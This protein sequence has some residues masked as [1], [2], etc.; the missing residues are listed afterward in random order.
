MQW[1]G[2]LERF[3]PWKTV[4]ERH[5][6]WSADGAWEQL[7]RQIQAAADAAGEIHW[8]V[9][10]DS[11]IAGR[12]STLSAPGPIRHWCSR[13]RGTKQQNT[14]AKPYGRVSTL[15]WWGVAGRKDLGR[16][17]GGFT[18]RLHLS[19]DGRCRPL[20]PIVAPGQRADCTQ[21]K[22]VVEKIRV[23]KSGPG[24]PRKKPDS[25]TTDKAYSNGPAAN[26][27]DDAASGT[28]SGE[29]RQSEPDPSPGE[30]R[31]RGRPPTPRHGQRRQEGG[32]AYAC[33]PF[34][35]RDAMQLTSTP[36]AAHAH[37]THQAAAV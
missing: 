17:R 2:L 20:S 19:T 3:G 34:R 27:C 5:R 8:D 13:Q 10:V 24:R 31:E 15:A 1:R 37:K 9:S 25:V 23:A 4:Y 29:D 21:F 26:A 32:G 28:P 7:L 22:P 14:G 12:I 36:P 11:T 30:S 6:L 35:S 33:F 16:S 18:S